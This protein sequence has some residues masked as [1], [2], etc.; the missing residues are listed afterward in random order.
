MLED[1]QFDYLLNARD[2]VTTGS[3][4]ISVSINIA[5][6]SSRSVLIYALLY[7][8]LLISCLFPRL[9]FTLLINGKHSVEFT[10][11]RNRGG[12]RL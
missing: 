4:A 7:F 2:N 5:L 10:M 9:K 1:N 12:I 6:K 8:N 11:H 3:F